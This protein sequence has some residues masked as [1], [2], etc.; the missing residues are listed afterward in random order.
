M[1]KLNKNFLILLAVPIMQLGISM[2]LASLPN[3]TIYFGTTKALIKNSITTYLIGSGVSIVT[4]G[5]FSKR[6]SKEFLILMYFSA[7]FL[8]SI[9]CSFTDKITWFLI[10]RFLQGVSIGCCPALVYSFLVD[11]F[12]NNLLIKVVSY[13]S[14]IDASTAV[15]SPFLGAIIEKYLDWRFNFIFMGIF[16]MFI[17]IVFYYF[18]LRNNFK[19]STRKSSSTSLTKYSEIFFIVKKVYLYSFLLI[20]SC[21]VLVSFNTISPFLL[22]HSYHLSKVMYGLIIMLI[23]SGY[24]IGNLIN[25]V[26]IVY[27]E[28]NYLIHIGLFGLAIYSTTLFYL[29]KSV[30]CFVILSTAIMLSIG[31]IYPN[32]M[33]IALK[34]IKY[35]SVLGSA[36]INFLI[37]IGI[38]ISN[39]II[40]MI[41]VFDSSSSVSILF[42]LFS[43]VGFIVNYLVYKGDKY[44]YQ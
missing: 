26:L 4:L 1:A 7:F 2:I 12:D 24:I 5:Y 43:I 38:S 18:L 35:N 30:V 39:F 6:Y 17:L 36:T 42:I 13:S 29:D 25:A 22:K 23:N 11:S 21:T 28:K 10:M 19:V 3:L 27:Y 14:A 32:Y 37:L 41:N 33:S 34:Q 44:A 15:F 40:S 8:V 31:F 16:S 9:A 20:I